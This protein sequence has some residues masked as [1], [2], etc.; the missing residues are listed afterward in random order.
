MDAAG[1]F[2]VVW[3]SENQDSPGTRG[4]YGQRFDAAGTRIGG[5]FLVNTT[6]LDNQDQPT[7]AMDSSGNF[8]V[9][10]WQ[11]GAS[12]GIYAQ[13]YN[14]S[15][16]RVGS[17][18]AV[19]AGTG[20]EH[21]QPTAAMAISSSPGADSMPTPAS[22]TDSSAAVSIQRGM[23]SAAISASTATPPPS[24]TGPAQASP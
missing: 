3:M 17:E 4:I 18:F 21:D 20:E 15:G 8:V 5:E 11:D 9:A 19:N 16:V 7:V 1:N 22:A 14:S 6:I 12:E 24:P 13:R 10:W 23:R 2:V